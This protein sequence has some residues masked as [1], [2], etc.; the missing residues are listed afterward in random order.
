MFDLTFGLF[1]LIFT[2]FFFFMWNFFP[3]NEGPGAVII[4]N[5][6]IIGF[7]AIGVWLTYKGIKK[8]VANK[9]T[10]MYGELCYGLITER[11]FNGNSI[12]DVRQYDAYVKVYIESEGRFIEA[13]ETIGSALNKYPVGSFYA[14]KYFEDDIN[15]EYQVPSI[16]G[17]PENVRRAFDTAVI[18]CN[19]NQDTLGQEAWPNQD[20]FG[21]EAWTNQD[22]LGQEAWPNS[23]GVYEQTDSFGNEEENAHSQNGGYYGDQ[24]N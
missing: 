4:P 11:R 14:V 22:A 9:K 2:L 5:I 18:P 8:V 10:D 16:N 6:I 13:H 21:Q 3:S 20:I 12:N 24:Y 15:F 7:I 17:L 1:W 23:Q 19:M